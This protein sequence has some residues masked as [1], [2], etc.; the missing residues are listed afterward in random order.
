[1]TPSPRVIPDLGDQFKID[2][3]TVVVL[4]TGRT[5]ITVKDTATGKTT[6]VERWKFTKAT[7]V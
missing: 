4:D 1:M 7:L 2:G 5:M 3:K 6:Q